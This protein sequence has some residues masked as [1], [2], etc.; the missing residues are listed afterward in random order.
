M[1]R[2]ASS[3]ASGPPLTSGDRSRP[4]S[5]WNS[6]N[7]GARRLASALWSRPAMARAVGTR[8]TWEVGTSATVAAVVGT[9]PIRATW[10]GTRVASS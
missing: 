8:S 4:G 3:P 1:A 5:G 6:V 7:D 10:N 9:S 2:L